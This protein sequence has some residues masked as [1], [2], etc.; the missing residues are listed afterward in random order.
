MRPVDPR[1]GDSVIY[2]NGHGFP[3]AAI[4]TGT[5]ESLVGEQHVAPVSSDLHLHLTVFSP[6]PRVYHEQDVP[7]WAGDDAP[8]RG[9]WAWAL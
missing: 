6:L 7:P 5:R 3:R 8:K 1:V 4:I 9:C 2:F